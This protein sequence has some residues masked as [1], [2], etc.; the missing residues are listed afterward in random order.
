M[1]LTLRTLLAYLDDLLEPNQAKELGAKIQESEVAAQQVMRIRDVVRKRRLTAP[2]VSGPGCDVDANLVAE[3]LDNTLVPEGV[4]RLEQICLESDVHL[5]EVAAS[6][7]ILT[8][9]LGEPID[10][11][12]HSRERMYALGTAPKATLAGTAPA[13]LVAAPVPF[14]ASAHASGLTS[15]QG[16][17]QHVASHL[18]AGHQGAG[19]Q[20]AGTQN[21][22]LHGG[23]GASNVSYSAAVSHGVTQTYPTSAVATSS[24]THAAPSPL[25]AKP[26]PVPIVANSMGAG[27]TTATGMGGL[28][29]AV[30]PVSTKPASVTIP[31]TAAVEQTGG[32]SREEAFDRT[33]PD[34]LKSPPIWKRALPLAIVAL[35]AVWLG[36]L[37]SDR[38]MLSN[39][40]GSKGTPGDQTVAQVAGGDSSKG[41]NLRGESGDVSDSGSNP[42]TAPDETASTSDMKPADAS[43]P[44]PPVEQ[45]NPATEVAA[46]NP[47]PAENPFDENPPADPEIVPSKENP[48]TGSVTPPMVA[49]NTGKGANGSAASVVASKPISPVAKPAA[50]T[51]PAQYVSQDGIVLR[52]DLDRKG[53][54]PLPHR[55]HVFADDLLAVPEPFDAQIQFGKEKNRLTVLGP[56]VVGV[57][58][59]MTDEPIGV[60]LERG[61]ILLQQAEPAE[62]DAPPVPWTIMVSIREK[63]WKVILSDAKAKCG[64]EVIPREPKAFE[65]EFGEESWSGKLYVSEGSVTVINSQGQESA[66]VGPDTVS[67]A[68]DPSV[69]APAVP[70]A[71]LPAWLGE[72]KPLPSVAE[73][74]AKQFEKEFE[75]DETSARDAMLGFIDEGFYEKSRLAVSC[76]GLIGDYE[77]MLTVLNKSPHRE[78]REAAIYAL[79]TWVNMAPENR[80]LLKTEI[81]KK[82]YPETADDLY[83][84]IWG[85]QESDA[86]SKQTSNQLVDWL[87]SDELAVRELAFYHI[88]RLTGRKLDFDSRGTPMHRNSSI[89]T[90][91]KILDKDGTLLPPQ[92]TKAAGISGVRR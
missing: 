84:L 59:P 12:H 27:M 2:A 30:K 73:R 89:Q 92:P 91:R 37:F 24:A 43:I 68:V 88:K 7:Q 66:L 62:V 56:A 86:R 3:Y 90:I 36:F 70:A 76:L 78:S 22:P 75:A 52:Y 14:V 28:A 25:V 44:A 58:D 46:L 17:S 31:S 9:V 71:N 1:R 35:V 20:G 60:N 72:R 54:F 53:W 48:K 11:S 49:A 10:I 40:L 51:N 79:R 50:V 38:E 57:I 6:H 55:A 67:L 8:L 33:I 15:H 61:R 18:G 32:R 85:Y 77:M 65:E 34:Y 5:A 42:E 64:I 74:T 81:S 26:A 69:T 16:A 87:E 39:L 23:V 4:Q 19:H 80:E 83:R 41:N 45:P 82:F 21:S 29:P 47:P 13:P 63:S